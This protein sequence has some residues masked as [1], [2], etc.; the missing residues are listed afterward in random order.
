[1]YLEADVWVHVPI[2]ACGIGFFTINICG[3][4]GHIQRPKQCDI[5]SFVLCLYWRLL[6][7]KLSEDSLE[8]FFQH[9]LPTTTIDIAIEAASGDITV[10]LVLCGEEL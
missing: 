7:I 3:N 1:M 6:S 2:P 9:R 10:T 4:L 8:P 5:L